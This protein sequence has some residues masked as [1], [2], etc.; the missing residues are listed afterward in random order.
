MAELILELSRRPCVVSGPVLFEGLGTVENPQCY[1]H[2]WFEW[3]DEDGA[4]IGAILEHKNG[5]VTTFY[6]PDRIKFADCG[7]A[8]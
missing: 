2:R 5:W 3:E 7:E 1:F 6:S 4:G 8:I